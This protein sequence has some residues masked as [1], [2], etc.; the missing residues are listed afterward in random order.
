MNTPFHNLC[1]L[2]Q[3]AQCRFL[4]T[5]LYTN[6]SHVNKTIYFTAFNAFQSQ[7]HRSPGVKLSIHRVRTHTL[8]GGKPQLLSN[9]T[10]GDRGAS[11]STPVCGNLAIYIGS[12]LTETHHAPAL[13]GWECFEANFDYHYSAKNFRF[14]SLH[15]SFE[16]HQTL[17]H[18]RAGTPFIGNIR[19]ARYC[20]CVSVVQIEPQLATGNR[21]GGY[22]QTIAPDFAL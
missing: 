19:Y 22:F 21:I 11:H 4:G 16:S 7:L 5:L 13:V 2:N 14:E 15:H 8:D 12:Q 6:C 3:H 10:A 9:C 20:A 1:G 17:H 18:L